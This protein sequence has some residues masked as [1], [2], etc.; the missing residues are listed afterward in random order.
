MLYIIAF[1][2]PF[3][4]NITPADTSDKT[5]FDKV[6]M[7]DLEDFRKL[8]ISDAI[9]SALKEKGFE[10]PTQIQEL[11]IPLLLQG[12]KDVIGQAQTGTGKTAAFGIPILDTLQRGN[13]QPQALILSPTRELCM[14]IADE[15]KT[16]RGNGDLRIAP[17]YGGQNIL[18]QLDKL[19]DGIDIAIGT[20]GRIIDLM[21]RKKLDLASLRFAVLDEA[22]EMLDMGFIDDIRR[23]LSGAP[24]EKR[25]LLFSATMPE[26]ILSIAEE[27]MRPGYQTIRTEFKSE[28]PV[29]TE[30]IFYEVRREHKLEALSR[31]LDMTPELYGMVFCRTKSDVDEL[32]DDLL[33][34]GFTVDALHGD[35][36]QAQRTRVIGNFKKRRFPLL[37]ATDVAARGLDINDLSHVINYS[38]PQNADTYIHRIGRTGRAGKAGCAITF[39]TPG[40]TARFGRI[41][42]AVKAEIRQCAI[43]GF[44]AIVQAKKQRLSEQI[45]S[46]IA[47]KEHSAF[48]GFAEELLSLADHP[49]EILAAMLKLRFKNEFS[50]ENYTDLNERPARSAD[51]KTFLRLKFSAGRKDGITVPSLLEIINEKTGIKSKFLG[52]IDLKDNCSFINAHPGDAR[53]LEESFRGEPRFFEILAEKEENGAADRIRNRRK[54]PVRDDAGSG[55][56]TI[57]KRKSF[58]EN[59][60]ESI[61]REMESEN[62]EKRKQFRNRKFRKS[63]NVPK[64]MKRR[65]GK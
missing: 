6:F 28:T 8:G 25:M 43:P 64:Q 10:K 52:R 53:K 59:F 7:N 1:Q 58:R 31:I 14:Q 61:R 19:R 2:F 38:I 11:T 44:E 20:P 42:K 41:R 49:A 3:P 40:E 62:G 34:R 65:D 37:I 23:I 45:Q 51:R 57:R 39:V 26:E 46:M 5:A 60:M 27:F 13:G 22:D 54:F 21:E 4:S 48:L 55:E 24:R 16:L 50:P 12:E 9:L 32:T 47:S 36:A 29:L 56:K 17:F 30:Q 35:L 63:G 15:L 33:A 18:I